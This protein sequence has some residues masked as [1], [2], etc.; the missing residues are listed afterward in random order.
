MRLL[1]R[2]DTGDFSLTQFGDGAI[3]PYAILSHTWGADAE[4]VTFEDLMNGTGKDKPGYVKIRFCGEQAGLDAL[5][6]FWIDTC[7]INKAN[8]AE[9][10]QAINSMYRW[11]R[12][13][14]RCYVYLSD[15]PSPPFGTNN[16]FNPQSW[17]SDFWKSKWFTRG[18]TL[19]ELLAP[20]SVEFFSRERKRLSDRSSLKQ[21]IQE[22]TGVPASALQGA[23][24]SQFSVDE[25][26]LWIERRQ[27]SVAED[28]VYSLLGI[29]DVKIPLF[30]G[31][32]ATNAFKR[33]REVIDKREKC[34]Q[35]LHLTDPRDDKKRIEDTKDGLLKDSYRWILENSDF[36]QWRDNQQSRLLWIKGDPGKGKTMLLC[37]IIN[38]L[39][40]STAK[41][42]LL[43]YFFCQATDSRINTATAVLRGLLYLLVNQ[44]PSL[45]S[46]V[47]KKYDSAG[48][49]LFEDSNAWV[50]LSEIFTNVLQ[51]PN[52]NST[53]LIV[54]ALDECVTDLP[55]LSDFIVK[56]TTTSPRVKWIVSSRNW[57]SIEKKLNTATQGTRL[58]LELNEKSVSAAVTSYIQC[59][60]DQLAKEN[61]YD[62]DTR[63]AV[64]R[65]LLSNAN[66]TF[67]WVAL[68][69]QELADI[70]GWD[71]EETSMTFPPGLHP[72]Y[73]RMLDQ[74]CS[75]K[76]AKLC[77]S[78]LA[79]ISAVY[80]P[81]TL[82]ELAS[83]VDMPARS[84]GSYKALAEII[85]LCG[86][87]LT[88]REHTVSFVHQSVKDF[89]VEKVSNEIYPSGKEE[90]HHEIFSRSLKVM[91]RT[92][93]RDIYR[94]GALGCPIERVKQPNPDPLAALRYS[95]IYWVD[96]LCN[97]NPNSFANHGIGSQDR[98]VIENFI[99]KKY[100]HWLEALSL[101]RSMSEG[102]LA[103]AKL[104]AL[105]QRRADAPSFIKLLQDAR[106][107]IMYHIQA[108]QN[109]PLQA[110]ASAL[111]FSPD[112]SLIRSY[113]KGEEPKWISIKPAIGDQWSA[114]LQ[115]LEGHSDWVWSVAF[116]HDSARLASA[117]GCKQRRLPPDARGP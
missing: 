60:V 40:K 59:K 105:A 97:W 70:P 64:Q 71:A 9:L 3:P 38:E 19:Q 77:K 69:C 58:C 25:R 87:F 101:C 104:N 79:L 62:N 48:K 83:F 90:T 24:L 55:K 31:E 88:L 98:G 18:W 67:L 65:Y 6:Y 66:G 115:T 12:N 4:E 52:L 56:K 21:Q 86:S 95:S 54:D 114:C 91:S 17:D 117:S 100:L 35:E 93:R 92:L 43:S 78:I 13:A 96:H 99:R 57:P 47:R 106:L 80:R 84:S 75:L 81:V 51:D 27:T 42:H 109:S 85:G 32:G 8:H 5:Q 44:Q 68:V 94:L 73:K 107:F 61:E 76:Y 108:I 28:K 102:V 74:I 46:H 116:S 26:F 11:Y 23:P 34:V 89:L 29:F 15:V 82:D 7:C 33:L 50:A 37:G 20:Y 36:Q 72:L 53:Y 39:K 2:S 10:S 41:T 113:F 22:I 110:Y 14:T 63:D 45:I 16:E 112:R 49:A 103:M 111:I 30:Y 1:R